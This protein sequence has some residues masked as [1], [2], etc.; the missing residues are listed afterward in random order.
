MH[1]S[2]G[3]GRASSHG[4]NM[5]MNSE[6]KKRL[7]VTLG[8]EVDLLPAVKS[9]VGL[10]LMGTDLRLSVEDL[11]HP[12]EVGLLSTE[13]RVLPIVDMTLTAEEVFLFLKGLE[14]RQE[15][16]PLHTGGLLLLVKGVFRLTDDL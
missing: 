10:P 7:N 6:G 16:V 2:V 11:V 8:V 14:L 9:L 1:P 13:D 5:A 4:T 12:V 15:T 3:D